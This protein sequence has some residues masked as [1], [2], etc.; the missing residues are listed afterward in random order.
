MLSGERSRDEALRSYARFSA[1]HS[2]AFGLALRLQWLVPRLP[3]RVLTFALRALA[4]QSL[5][6]RAF[7]WYLD[8]AHPAFLS[9]DRSAATPPRSI[10]QPQVARTPRFPGGRVG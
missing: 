6:D 9:A 7:G 3:P 2:R 10:R 1:S 5:V 4:R 8:Q